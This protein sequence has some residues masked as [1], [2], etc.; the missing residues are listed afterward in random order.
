[1]GWVLMF[2][3]VTREAAGAR[4]EVSFPPIPLVDCGGT[5]LSTNHSRQ[6]YVKQCGYQLGLSPIT[7]DAS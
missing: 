5:V 3:R 6:L 4:S 1:M 2:I 7:C